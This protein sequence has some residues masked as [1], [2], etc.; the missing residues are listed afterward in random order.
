MISFHEHVEITL[1]P[2]GATYAASTRLVYVADPTLPPNV[3]REA[4]DDYEEC[5]RRR[6][7]EVAPAI[8][9]LFTP[10]PGRTFDGFTWRP[11]RLDG[12]F[13]HDRP[14]WRDAQVVAC[15]VVGIDLSKLPAFETAPATCIYPSGGGLVFVA[16]L[17]EAIDFARNT[18]AHRSLSQ[19]SAVP[20]AARAPR[21]I[22][23][24]SR[25]TPRL[26]SRR[27]R[28]SS[29]P[30]RFLSPTGNRSPALSAPSI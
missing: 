25:S 28:R 9:S 23:R 15:R 10:L 17:H 30:G 12:V 7:A 5:W 2:K 11:C 18:G 19:R 24:A 8:R 3:T 20:G 14:A 13:P 1:L 22:R 21:S 6:A 29:S 16:V 27:I 4:G 26:T